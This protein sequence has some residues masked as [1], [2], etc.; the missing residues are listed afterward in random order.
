MLRRFNKR[1]IRSTVI[2]SF[3]PLTM[4]AAQDD[5]KAAKKPELIAVQVKV[6]DK[7]T[8]TAIEN[9]DVR[10]KWGQG[11]GSDSSS[12]TTTASG[13]ARIKDVPRGAVVIR[14]IANGYVAVAPPFDL[15]KEQQPIKIELDK[16]TPGHD[17][18][19]DAPPTD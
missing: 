5:T 6:T 1:L 13:I 12:S 9:A 18:G 10:V 4:P 14:V 19:K 15:K 7:K 8:G 2:L 16:E 11:P 17:S 3:L